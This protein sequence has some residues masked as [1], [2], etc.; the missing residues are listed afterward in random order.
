LR[1]IVKCYEEASAAKFQ[2]AML[3]IVYRL[4]AA[5]FQVKVEHLSP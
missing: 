4:K 5:G 3:P 1:I 2:D